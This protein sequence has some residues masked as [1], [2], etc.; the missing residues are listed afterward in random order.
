MYFSNPGYDYINKI[1]MVSYQKKKLRLGP[2]HEQNDSASFWTL[3]GGVVMMTICNF[4]QSYSGSKT[5]VCKCIEE[6]WKS[7]L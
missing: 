7:G 6:K 1:C 3:D 4:P 2:V 5:Q